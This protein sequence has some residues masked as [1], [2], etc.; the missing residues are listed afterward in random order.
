VS[1]NVVEHFV[2]HY[3]FQ[4]VIREHPLCVLRLLS[5]V[6]LVSKRLTHLLVELKKPV[7]AL[8]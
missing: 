5:C 8:L 4:E 6:E 1:E 3:K 2:G 7:N